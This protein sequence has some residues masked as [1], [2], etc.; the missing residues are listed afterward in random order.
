[1][2]AIR[3]IKRVKNNRVVINLPVSLNN[4][5]IEVIIIPR[6]KIKIETKLGEILLNGPTLSEEQINE[7]LECRE[8]LNN[9]KIKEF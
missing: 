7:F 5:E 3:K 1:M 9:W 4:E 2:F 8:D 6:K